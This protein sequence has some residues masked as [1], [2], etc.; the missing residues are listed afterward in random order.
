MG[1]NVNCVTYSR[2]DQL[3]FGAFRKL[4]LALWAVGAPGVGRGQLPRDQSLLLC[5]RDI[6]SSGPIAGS[7]QSGN[8]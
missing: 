5:S 2:A 4:N 1:E 8:G 7:G 3:G 6:E